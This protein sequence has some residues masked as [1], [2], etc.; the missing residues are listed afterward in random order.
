MGQD[1]TRPLRAPWSC[2]R[3]TLPRPLGACARLGDLFEAQ[4]CQKVL[5]PP[6]VVQANALVLGVCIH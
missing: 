1:A 4:L 2:Q 5:V 3:F 6:E